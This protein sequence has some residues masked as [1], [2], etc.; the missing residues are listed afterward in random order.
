MSKQIKA[1]LTIIAGTIGVGFLILPYSVY[2]F[3]TFLGIL[4]LMLVGILTL[5]TNITYSDIIT[6]DKGNRQIPGYTKK[7]LGEV[8]GHL[9][10]FIMI[11]G[12]LGILLA[13]GIVSGSAL[14]VIT[15]ALGLELSA[16]FLGLIFVVF[17]LFVMR[18]G[19][20]IIARVSSWA[21]IAIFIAIF[22][23][24]IISVPNIS[25]SNATSPD[26][27]AFPLIFGGSIFALYSAASIPVVDEL[28]GYNRTLYRKVI[29][30]AT[31]VILL[32]YIIFALVISLSLG[33]SLTGELVDSF[34]GQKFAGLILS[35]LTLLAT[36]TSFVLVANS[37]KEILNYDY[38]IP[39]LSATLFIS[40]SLILAFLLE[41]S[42]FDM[43]I[44]V[45]GNIALA[46]QSLFI[47]AIWFRSQKKVGSLYR[48]IVAISGIILLLGM[49][50]QF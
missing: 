21:V 48:F 17:A 47:F 20:Q 10:S 19:M 23:L 27:E 8:W 46:L 35:F 3:G 7:Y 15:S 14:Q 31:I 49:L 24:I 39:P 32:I 36:F 11:I 44:S 50:S 29:K 16:K 26:L 38:K 33:D 1:I 42:D 40:V 37:V 6:S 9:V 25:L 5:I 30:L 12:S 18:Y 41:V 13:Y 2:K 28:I 45:V 22:F 34:S 4:V 43:L